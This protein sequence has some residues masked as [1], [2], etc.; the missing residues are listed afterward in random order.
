MAAWWQKIFDFDRYDITGPVKTVYSVIKAS[1]GLSHL[2]NCLSVTNNKYDRTE[3][4]QSV[5]LG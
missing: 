3:I 2:S 4:S 5:K 1:N